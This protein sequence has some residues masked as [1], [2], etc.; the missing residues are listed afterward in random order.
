MT[1][2]QKF[3]TKT[4]SLIMLFIIAA[5]VFAFMEKSQFIK[6]ENYFSGDVS[7]IY[8]E[9]EESKN[10]NITLSDISIK[11]ND[12]LVYQSISLNCTNNVNFGKLSLN[13]FATKEEIVEIKIK[14]DLF[15]TEYLTKKTILT[16]QN[17]NLVID[18]EADFNFTAGEVLHLEIDGLQNIAIGLLKLSN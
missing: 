18:I 2:K 6:I 11:N 10:K 12:L 15:S 5:T 14:K 1:D 9:N 17:K 16:K 13:I 4:I 8:F 7:V 3:L